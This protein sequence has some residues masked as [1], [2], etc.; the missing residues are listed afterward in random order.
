MENLLS[1]YTDNKNGIE[2]AKDIL[3]FLGFMGGIKLFLNWNFEKKKKRI[4][5]N[6]KFR[7]ELE[8]QLQQY[9]L[10]KYQNDIKDIGIRFVH[11][12]NYPWGLKNDGFKHSLWLR[13]LGEGVMP[14]GWIDNTGVN[15]SEHLWFYGKSVY[16]DSDGIFFFD[17]AGRAVKGFEELNNVCWI[18]HMPFTNIVNFDFKEFIEYEPVFYIRYPYTKIKKLYDDNYIIR[19]KPGEEYYRAELS[20]SMQIK[21]PNSIK[22]WYLRLSIFLK[23]KDSIATPK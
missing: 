3:Y 19:E 23:S 9:V 11:W 5:E 8:G 18:L 21:K 12:K 17:K 4:S 7:D 14:S 22:H 6:L 13:N 1:L 10:D 16:V 15:I 20:R 2:L